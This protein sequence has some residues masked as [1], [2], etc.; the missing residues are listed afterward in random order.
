MNAWTYEPE[1][2]ERIVWWWLAWL[3][4]REWDEPNRHR[5]RG[6]HLW[7]V[8]RQDRNQIAI[9]LKP[10]ERAFVMSQLHVDQVVTLGIMAVDSRGNQVKFTPD[11]TP[12]WTNSNDAAATSKVSPDGLTNVLTPVAGGEGQV[13]TASVVVVIGGVQFTASVDETIVSGGVAGIKITETFSQ[14]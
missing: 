7:L 12:V 11:T 5:H 8:L 4:V 14:G 1:R 3:R 10:R 2:K 6:L 13:D 9:L